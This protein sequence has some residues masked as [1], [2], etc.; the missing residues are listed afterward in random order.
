VAL[1]FC[2]FHERMFLKPIEQLIRVP[3]QVMTDHPFVGSMP[4]SH[5]PAAPL[6]ASGDPAAPGE[7]AA[8]PAPARPSLLPGRVRSSRRR[9]RH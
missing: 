8:P 4:K 2:D 5:R 1:S 6:T 3:M 7:P 9:G